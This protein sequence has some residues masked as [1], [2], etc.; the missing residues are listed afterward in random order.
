MQFLRPSD[1]TKNTAA[2]VDKGNSC[3]PCAQ[4]VLAGSQSIKRFKSSTA[5]YRCKETAD[6]KE[7]IE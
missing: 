4:P 6:E 1:E 5:K 2:A 3:S 7:A